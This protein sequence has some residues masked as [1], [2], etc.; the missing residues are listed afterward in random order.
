ML[1]GREV[2]AFVANDAAEY[3]FK[4]LLGDGVIDYVITITPEMSQRAKVSNYLD[5]SKYNPAN[6]YYA[7]KYS[8][9][10]SEDLEFFSSNIF[11]IGLILGWNRLIPSKIINTFT[12]GIIGFHGTPFG[13]PKGR[14]RSPAIWSIVLGYDTYF[15][16]AF[17]VQPGID[18]GPIYVTKAIRIESYD[19]IRTFYL[20]LSY[21]LKDMALE[22]MEK[23]ISGYQGLPQ[24]G[25]PIYF[26]KR[27]EKDG[28][29]R[30]E[31]GAWRVYNLV[32]AI[33]HPYPGAWT[34]YKG[35]KIRIWWGVPFKEAKGAP[36]EVIAVFDEGFL[37]GCGEDSFLVVEYTG[38]KPEVGD[39][40]NAKV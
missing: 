28:Y 17:K 35:E 1:R 38:K 8:L 21:V 7:K 32:R 13:L 25:T 6:V 31:L 10:S 29:I 22:A 16:H 37:V 26:R 27:D 12:H 20:K 23:L 14:G 30:W 3:A 39:Y 19:N 4:E 34:W 5:V 18:D 11:D 15:Y 36:G 24:V 2:V 40:L 9:K 33:T